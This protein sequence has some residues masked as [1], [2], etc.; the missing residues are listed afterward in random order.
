LSRGKIRKIDNYIKYIEIISVF[1]VFWGFRDLRGAT[2]LG[3]VLNL[4]GI[5]KVNL[6]AIIA[7][8]HCG[9]AAW[10]RKSG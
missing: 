6:R 2:N 1:L 9:V 4:G 7:G 5:S 3:G 8:S 10:A